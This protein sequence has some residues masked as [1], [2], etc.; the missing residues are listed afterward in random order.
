MYAKYCVL[1]AFIKILS[2]FVKNHWFF[3]QNCDFE[4]LDEERENTQTHRHTH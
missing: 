4:G 3:Q 1:Q 2:I